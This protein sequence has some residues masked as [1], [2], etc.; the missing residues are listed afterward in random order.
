MIYSPRAQPEVNE[1][2][3]QEVPQNNWLN[4]HMSE[5]SHGQGI[6]WARYHMGKVSTVTW[7]C[8]LF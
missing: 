4:F 6:T 8:S 5:V 1:S 2:H 7:F 3:I